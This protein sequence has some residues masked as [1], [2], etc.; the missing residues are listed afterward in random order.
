MY[1]T[2]FYLFVAIGAFCGYKKGT[3]KAG[4]DF[5]AIGMASYF[6]IWL[7]PFSLMVLEYIP[8]EYASYSFLAVLLISAIVLLSLIRSGI[9]QLYDSYPAFDSEVVL[10]ELPLINNIF[11]GLLGACSGFFLTA[12][13]LF[14]VTFSPFEIPYITTVDF[15]KFTD[16]KVLCCSRAVNHFASGEWN[17]KQ[18]NYLEKLTAQFR[19]RGKPEAQEEEKKDAPADIKPGSKVPDVGVDTPAQG[20]TGDVAEKTAAQKLASKAVE[21]A[22]SNQKRAVNASQDG[23]VLK[24]GKTKEELAQQGTQIVNKM[25][26]GKQNS[27]T[28]AANTANTAMDVLTTGVIPEGNTVAPATPAVPAAPAKPLPGV[29]APWSKGGKYEIPGVTF[30]LLIPE[31]NEDGT[32]SI[33]TRG[34]KLGIRLDDEGKVPGLI[35]L[36]VPHPIVN[37]RDRVLYRRIRV[38]MSTV[39]YAPVRNLKP[40]LDTRYDIVETK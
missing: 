11:G 38:D 39:N 1:E 2:V 12:F 21:A 25:M 32:N 29:A 40:E 26:D 7:L 19:K 18:K 6:S 28:S 17:E 33:H 5:T 15:C 10:S 13:V 14:V 27:A 16:E 37:H 34:I 4:Y 23:E 35:D 8:A 9:T 20:T 3:A 31:L 30:T 36:H 24:T 22:S